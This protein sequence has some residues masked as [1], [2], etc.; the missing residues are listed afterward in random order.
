MKLYIIGNGFDLHHGLKTSYY[1]YRE[2]LLSRSN[3]IVDDFESFEYFLNQPDLDVLW[4]NLE[5]SMAFDYEEFSSRLVQD[6]YPDLLDDSD[7]RWHNMEVESELR[8]EF[9]EGFVGE[10]FFDWIRTV[11]TQLVDVKP[12][13]DMDKEA[14]FINFNYTDTLSRIYDINLENI[15]HIHGSVSEND[16][17]GLVFGSGDNDHQECETYLVKEYVMDVFYGASI[18]SAVKTLVEF[19]RL[20]S[21]NIKRNYDTLTNFI[22]GNDIDEVVIMGHSISE[23]SYDKGYYEDV[24][25]KHLTEDVLWS[26]YGYNEKDNEDILSFIHRNRILNY[27]LMNWK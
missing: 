24:I 20:T 19:S 5:K 27:R 1:H 13:L 17:N 4:N 21:K 11:T 14:L 26:I 23:S 16:G 18:E 25:M 6:Y 9:V 2:Y 15:L 8:T 3:S 12:K 7:S 10:Y 22:T